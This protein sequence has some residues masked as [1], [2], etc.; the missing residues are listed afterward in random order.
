[1]NAV[2]TECAIHVADLARLKQS[3]LATA[4][5]H[6]IRD[7]LTPATNAVQGMATCTHVLIPHL[8]FERRKGRGHKVELSDGADIFAETR[9]AKEAIDNHSRR[10]VTYNDPGSHPG[11]IPKAERLIRP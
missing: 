3:Q 10:E 8:H 1:M 2:Q 11:L 7:G 6:Q 4:Y 9:A 5:H